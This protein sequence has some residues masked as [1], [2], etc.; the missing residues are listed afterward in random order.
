M[1]LL[2]GSKKRNRGSPYVYHMSTSGKN[3]TG[4]AVT[5]ITLAKLVF[6]FLLISIFLA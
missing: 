5:C 4:F 1:I 2:L 3:R 6:F